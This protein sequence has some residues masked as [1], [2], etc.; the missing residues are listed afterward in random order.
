MAKPINICKSTTKYVYIYISSDEAPQIPPAG[1]PL[2]PSRSSTTTTTTNNTTTTTTTTT[3]PI[4][5][6]G[7]TPHSQ[8]SST[9]HTH[10]H[11]D[12]DNTTPKTPTQTPPP[13]HQQIDTPMRHDVDT[14]TPGTA[15][16]P[17]TPP[18]STNRPKPPKPPP[19]PQSSMSASGKLLQ[20]DQIELPDTYRPVYAH[21]SILLGV[22]APADVEDVSGGEDIVG[23]AAEE[24]VDDIETV[25]VDDVDS[26]ADADD[27]DVDMRPIMSSTI[28]D[29]VVD[30]KEARVAEDDAP[31]EASQSAA[32]A[33]TTNDDASD[34]DDDEDVDND[35]DQTCEYTDDDLD[36]ALQSDPD[37][38]RPIDR[39]ATTIGQPSTM[40]ATDD[41][42]PPLCDANENPYML[43][44]PRK[45]VLSASENNIHLA[46]SST[47][48]AV[49]ASDATNA[50]AM[51]A[52]EPRDDSTYVEMFIN[53]GKA[54]AAVHS[55]ADDYKSAYELVSFGTP[56]SH[57][58][59]HKRTE[60]EPVYME[61][62]HLRLSNKPVDPKPSSAAAVVDVVDRHLP[63]KQIVAALAHA[64]GRSTIR[65][66]VLKSKLGSDATHKKQR[67]A[68][69]IKKHHNL[70]DIVKPSQTAIGMMV[71]TNT[72]DD[73]SDDADDESTNTVASHLKSGSRSRF[74]LSDTFRPASYY[75][76]ASPAVRSAGQ[77]T[78]AGGTAT[79]YD[80]AD[81]SDSSEVVSPPPI[82]AS[83]P[84]NEQQSEEAFAADHCDTIRRR[85]ITTAM[86]SGG[87]KAAAAAAAAAGTLRLSYEQLPKGAHSSS[88]SLNSFKRD[89]LK[90]SR[91]SLPDQFAKW[92]QQQLQ[93]QNQQQHA[94]VGSYLLSPTQSVGQMQPH[95]QHSESSYSY[96]TD[97]SSVASSD[98]DIASKCPPDV[99]LRRDTAT[100]AAEQSEQLRL[101]KRRPLSEDSLSEIAEM[102]RT[103]DENIAG[104]SPDLDVYLQSLENSHVSLYQNTGLMAGSVPF[105]RPPEVFRGDSDTEAAF[106]GN[107]RFQRDERDMSGV[108]VP[109]HLGEMV[110]SPTPTPA[111]ANL[112]AAGLS[113]PLFYDSLEEKQ[114]QAP[115]PSTS[116]ASATAVH[117][118]AGLHS[119][120]SSTLSDSVPYYY[121]ELG[122]EDDCTPQQQ[123]AIG[124]TTI[125]PTTPPKLLNNL[126]DM[127]APKRPSSTAGIAL[128][129]NPIAKENLVG[130]LA[131]HND[132]KDRHIENK[133]LFGLASAAA[134]CGEKNVCN[135]DRAAAVVVGYAANKLY[136]VKP[137]NT[138]VVMVVAPQA[139]AP[140]AADSSGELHWEADDMWRESLRRVS[141]R[142]ARSLDAL[143]RIETPQPRRQQQPQPTTS[144]AAVHQSP[145]NSNEG[146][147]GPLPPLPTDA[148]AT[149]PSPKVAMRSRPPIK[150]SPRAESS[151]AA[152]AA[153]AAELDE[154][155]VY[156]QLM[157][158]QQTAD[159]Y[160]RLKQDNV[161]N[162]RKSIEINRDLIRQWDSMSS[163]LMKSGPAAAVASSGVHR[164]FGGGGG[165]V[166]LSGGRG[167][168][169]ADV[170][171]GGGVGG[172]GGAGDESRAGALHGGVTRGGACGGG[173][174]G[175]G[176]GIVVVGGSCGGAIVGEPSRSATLGMDAVNAVT[177]S[178]SRV[179]VSSDGEHMTTLRRKKQQPPTGS[180]YQH[181]P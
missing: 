91:L 176:G 144:K 26:I 110:R 179:M 165:G 52:L 57:R 133:N 138:N 43:M 131:L 16:A 141:H 70:P 36:E 69:N 90:T 68:C 153:A 97:N 50:A 29:D 121:A 172:E 72:T 96:H 99:E 113:A 24:F 124:S 19:K 80:F 107:I 162:S 11:T 181:A 35:D 134:A 93:H 34:D 58:S 122:K 142:H 18:S 48:T 95:K 108:P 86:S 147:F 128:I 139:P 135:K 1:R 65:K 59:A 127:V 136:G 33:L 152:V 178:S 40:F 88:S 116:E 149:M 118:S 14:A 74:S 137:I 71:T 158:G 7:H 27:A 117:S 37:D 31:D 54:S 102:G 114:S 61:L 155:D 38:R 157:A 89:G 42:E 168:G 84:P 81:S 20:L 13:T 132:A 25:V 30:E 123:A 75:L 106:Y 177:G 154:H 180:M 174:D 94:Q 9:P 60:S 160:E 103:F 32:D 4:T 15:Q 62:S 115:T 49:T 130:S 78:G 101:L 28:A 170:C 45:S 51:Q 173:D 8:S 73:S 166:A 41:G 119:R 164:A 63:A 21:E 111:M 47:L 66:S 3:M 67:T 82:P 17:A 83:P 150:R 129:Q 145:R 109:F 171:G 87:D 53:N 163:G 125:P 146:R 169:A 22:P 167:G 56:S 6:P 39:A 175:G 143:D 156:V 12:F 44:T 46:S 64:D 105:I 151:A 76:G 5:F 159:M 100:S 55:P 104:V 126:R 112:A 79:A 10:A 85:S 148:V 120:T 23:E 140:A 92:Q 98:Y 2:A 161:P 77:S